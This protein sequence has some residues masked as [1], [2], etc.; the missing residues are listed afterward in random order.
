MSVELPALGETWIRAIDTAGFALLRN[1]FRSEQIAGWLEEIA[2]TFMQERNNAEAIRSR[3]GTVYAARNV[4]EWFPSAR[5]LWCV[6][7]LKE[8]L[9]DVLGSEYGL[10][11]ALY[12][13][14]P[15]ERTWTLPWHKDLT[16]AVR[17][18]AGP[19]ERF[20][21]PTRKAGVAHVEAPLELL[22][23]MLT[24]RIH[25]DEV[26]TE[27]GPLRVV[28]GSHREGK[29]VA[30][31]ANETTILANAG[32]VLAIR[33]LVTHASGASA[34]GTTLHRRILHLEFAADP[35]LG[36]GFAWHMFVPGAN[37]A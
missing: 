28:P 14:K 12:F 30:S 4:L 5:R 10:V 2:K 9:S 15:P 25:L 8:L 6:E 26:T 37:S 17:K 18:H 1:V 31:T 13:D 21:R 23:R 7:P 3:E 16:I 32:D 34:P 29:E 35:T 19:S 24:L 33:P 20:T 27:N 11:R 22:E 36:D